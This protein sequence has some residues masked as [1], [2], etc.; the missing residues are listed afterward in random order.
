MA[1]PRFRILHYPKLSNGS[2]SSTPTSQAILD[3]AISLDESE[4][5]KTRT[6]GFQFKINNSLF[7]LLK[8]TGVGT[9]TIPLLNVDDRI[10]I[11]LW[12]GSS[13]QT[14]AD[15]VMDGYITEVKYSIEETGKHVSV[16]GV[17]RTE[18]L[19]NTL[20]PIIAED[21]KRFSTG[22]A[23]DAI[24]WMINLLKNT[25]PHGN[26]LI[27]ASEAILD[28]NGVWQKG[29]YI[30][31]T[32]KKIEYYESYKTVY[33]QIETLSTNEY[34]GNGQY[35]F[36][37]D[38]NNELHWVPKSKT[39]RVLIVEGGCTGANCI[40]PLKIQLSTG[41]YDTINAMII[42]CGKDARGN[43]VLGLAYDLVSAASKG[44]RWKYVAQPRVGSQFH[45]KNLLDSNGNSIDTNQDGFP[46]SYPYT[47]TGGPPNKYGFDSDGKIQTTNDTAY[48]DAL[49]KVLRYQGEKWGNDICLLFGEP[50]WKGKII[51]KGTTEYTAGELVAVYSPS[52]LGT[53]SDATTKY[54]IL[55][56]SSL[57]HSFTTNGWETTLT[58]KQDE[59]SMDLEIG[60]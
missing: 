15:M 27:K 45:Q 42:N 57:S 24:I 43:T 52:I 35:I 41:M 33:E 28:E 25:D 50:R 9:E 17:N 38:L 20:V 53:N 46:D 55:R 12:Y 56:I 32:T 48:N 8:P 3:E 1:V 23:S 10:E 36:W 4:G 60:V 47:V 54:I 58:L 11:Y 59:R 18:R 16:D 49:R 6:D 37:L 5:I 21:S 51:V 13:D 7:H 44:F 31:P 39:A 22:R 29:G 14:S 2:W 30:Y 19:L 34:T 26:R 40:E